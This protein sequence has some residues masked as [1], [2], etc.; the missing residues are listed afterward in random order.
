MHNKW[1]GDHFNV[2]NQKRQRS[3][4]TPR[5]MKGAAAAAV[6]VIVS[7]TTLELFL[8]FLFRGRRL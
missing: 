8:F 4:E 7:A 1:Q 5:S 6:D 2:R 3:K